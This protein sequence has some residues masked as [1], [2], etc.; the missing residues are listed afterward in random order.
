M[1]DEPTQS[2]AQAAGVNRSTISKR[3]AYLGLPPRK[4]G[5]KP[6]ML[7]EKKPKKETV[8]IRCERCARQYITDTLPHPRERRVCPDGC[9]PIPVE[10][11]DGTLKI[12]WN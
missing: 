8:R 3:A 6:G 11:A 2:I 12:Y 4:P 10:Q 5:G 7:K 9:P 1:A